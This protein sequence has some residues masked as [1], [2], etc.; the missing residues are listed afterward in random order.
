MQAKTN[1]PAAA[2]TVTK[3]AT[4]AT[5][6][7]TQAHVIHADVSANKLLGSFWSIGVFLVGEI[8]R[9]SCRERVSPRV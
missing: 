5:Q 2:T 1:N 9:A 4:A 8:G 3:P 6:S 7:A